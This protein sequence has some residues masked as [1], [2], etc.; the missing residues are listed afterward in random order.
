MTSSSYSTLLYQ[1]KDRI[2]HIILNRPDRF[3][4]INHELPVELQNA[5]EEANL[6]EDVHVIVLS[7][8]GKAFC[9]GY[10]LKVPGL[11]LQLLN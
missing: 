11:T 8:A 10:D 5:V 4:A 6:D 7:G 9:S 1:K 2:A 3:N